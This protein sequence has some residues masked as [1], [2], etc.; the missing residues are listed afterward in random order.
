MISLTTSFPDC[1]AACPLVA[2]LKEEIQELGEKLIDKEE[3][4]KGLEGELRKHDNPHTPSSQKR[5][6]KTKRNR[7]GGKAGEGTGGEEEDYGERF[8]GKPKGSNGGGISLPEPD[9]VKHHTLEEGG[10]EEI[11]T[12][13]KTVIELPEK[14]F[15]VVR[16]VIYIYEDPQGKKVEPEVDLP[17]GIYGKRLQ[18]FVTLLRGT[19]GASHEKIAELVHQIRPDL[20]FSPTTSLNITDNTSK[21]LKEERQKVLERVNQKKYVHMDETG[22][23]I[24]GV[25]GW[26]WVFAHQRDVGYV[27]SQS[28]SKDIPEETMSGYDGTGVVDGCPAYNSFTKQR[29]WEHLRREVE[30]TEIEVAVTHYHELYERAKEAKKKPPPDRERFIQEAWNSEFPELI[31]TLREN[32]GNEKAIKAATKIENALPDMFRGVRDPE[33]PLTNNH[34]ERLL[35][36]IVTHRKLWGCIRNEKGKRFIENTLS[37]METWK[38]QDKNVFQELQK[39]TS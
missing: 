21:R 30:E 35:R 24:D 31:K 27:V 39:F 10:L 3:R 5:K 26:V 32:R 38:L 9:H 19:C 12:R 8:P 2:E 16:H 23:R 22:L 15:E 29:D 11:G 34:A 25:N 17:E 4:I 37:C 14:I 18:A 20:S 36:K 7:K 13:E 33:I 28:R 6:G 1:S